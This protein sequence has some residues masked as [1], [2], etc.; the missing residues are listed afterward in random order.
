MPP[1]F[2]NVQSF[3]PGPGAGAETLKSLKLVRPPLLTCSNLRSFAP[4]QWAGGGRTEGR[5]CGRSGC[6][7]KTKAG[8]PSN[9]ATHK[10]GMYGRSENRSITQG[11][12]HGRSENRSI[13]QGM[14]AWSIRWR[15]PTFRGEL[16][17]RP[18]LKVVCSIWWQ[19]LLQR[20]SVY[21]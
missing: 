20:L 3:V 13:M 1:P 15:G 21:L 8:L 2:Q 10:A 6:R 17:G 4:G 14:H 12:H 9:E 19:S 16:G 7:G 11:H 18:P 5:P